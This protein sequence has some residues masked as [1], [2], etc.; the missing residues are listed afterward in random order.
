MGVLEA[1]EEEKTGFKKLTT[2]FVRDWR[3]KPRQDLPDAPKQFLRRSRLVA[4]EYAVDRRDDVHSPATGGQTL[5]LLPIIYLMKKLEERD[6]GEEFWLGSMDVKD[7]FLQVPQEEPTQVRTA[8]GHYEVKRNL[9]GQ[10]QGAKAWFDYFT[11]WL[12]KR[13]FQFS[14]I[15][16]CL[17]RKEDRMMVL[18]HVD[19]VLY[20]GSR[21]YV[22]KIF[23]PDIKKSF[24]ISE[25]HL[26]GD[27]TTFSFLRRTYEQAPEGLKILPGK[28]AENTIEQ[29]ES[30]LGRAKIQKL[31]CGPEMLEQ[32]GTS[33]V[34]GEL[35]SLFRSLVGC[36]IYLSQE[37]MDVSFAI[38]ELASSMACPTTGSL[39]KLGKLVGYL[40]A[41]VGQY[42]LLPYPDPGHGHA[43]RTTSSRWLL[44][45][46]TDSDWSGAKGHRRSTSAAVHMVNGNVVLASSR[47]QKSVSLS[48]AEAELNALVS[49]AADG[50]YLRRCLEFLMEEKVVHHC[51]VDN[52]AALHLCH[53]KGPGKLRHIAGKLLWIQDMVAQG[54]LEVKAVGTVANVADLG[55]KPLAKARVNLIL[56]W[57][58]IYNGGGER[59]G[60]EEQQRLE[61]SSVSRSKIQRLAKLLN[62]ILLL[63]GLE[64]VA[65]E[66]VSM[67]EKITVTN[68]TQWLWAFIVVLM[69]VIAVLIFGIYQL[70]KRLERMETRL[71][72]VVDDVKVDG[73]MVGAYGHETKEAIAQVKKYVEKV[74]RGLIKASGYVD[75]D[76]VLM[77]DWRHWDYLQDT[78]KE[79]DMR[80]LDKQIKD[81]LQRN[82]EQT[83]RHLNIRDNTL[84]DE[85]SEEGEH[86][87]DDLVQVRL[88]SGEVV[89]VRAGELQPREPESE[90]EGPAPMETEP[91][92][93]PD[94]TGEARG[95]GSRDLEFE[96]LTLSAPT[97]RWLT[98]AEL[99]EVSEYDKPAARP[100]LRAKQYSLQFE[101]RWFE[102][103]QRN[104]HE[105]KMEMYARMERHMSFLDSE[106]VPF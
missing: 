10:R 90:D 38:K 23:L 52:S 18:I 39:R 13:G 97:T 16:P 46:F 43:T 36:G 106:A 25:Q 71:Q 86:D 79:F 51:L 62:R 59:I 49:G 75:D 31:P 77:E 28:Y 88:E 34:S 105:S 66:R 9:P 82:V 1:M 32:D 92:R 11:D 84:R 24:D 17:G 50:I 89:T 58:Q 33:M 22:E 5:R 80:R 55:T 95:S 98:D 99:H 35:A 37:R 42:S 48:S 100:C 78:N 83:R 15:N 94:R 74:H 21:E 6:G 64:H 57:C 12:K 63:E 29:Y 44:E 73:V 93:V 14:D 20:L 68:H 7:P 2:R 70:W 96:D 47:G 30:Q 26:S 4:R 56:H 87:P 72:Q 53:R 45:T 81:Y 8:R 54:D 27:G 103:N 91:E 104:E 60:Q 67:E 101:K 19:D 85:E 3:V 40:K 61:E 41:T 76:E 69:M 65:G 102:L